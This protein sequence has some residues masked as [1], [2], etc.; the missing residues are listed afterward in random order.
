MDS[1]FYSHLHNKKLTFISEN[2]P[3][4]TGVWLKE[5]D[6]SLLQIERF[7]SIKILL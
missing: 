2:I 5:C 7:L 4:H 6:I 1:H 3:F